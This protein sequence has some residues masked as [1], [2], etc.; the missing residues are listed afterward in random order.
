MSHPHNEMFDLEIF[1]L[2]G[3]DG[4]SLQHFKHITFYKI[5]EHF[6]GSAL[7]IIDRNFFSSHP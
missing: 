3:T 4:A 6:G 2:C 5:P 7:H 1:L